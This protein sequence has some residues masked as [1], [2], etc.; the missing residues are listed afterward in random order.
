MHF[1][2]ERGDGGE[3]VGVITGLL[4]VNTSAPAGMEVVCWRAH[5]SGWCSLV[6]PYFFFFNHIQM[7]K[8]FWLE[9]RRKGHGALLDG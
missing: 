8:N 2:E 9:L 6:A 4:I 1:R 3:S 5:F 7:G